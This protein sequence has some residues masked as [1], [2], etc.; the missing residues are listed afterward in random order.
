MANFIDFIAQL[1]AYCFM[2]FSIIVVIIYLLLQLRFVVYFMGFIQ[3]IVARVLIAATISLFY[4]ICLASYFIHGD[5]LQFQLVDTLIF[6]SFIM[7]SSVGILGI[8]LVQNGGKKLADTKFYG[9]AHERAA[10]ANY[11]IRI[12][13][14]QLGLKREHFN[15]VDEINALF[16]GV[17]EPYPDEN[18]TLVK[19]KQW[20]E[21]E[22]P[23]NKTKVLETLSFIIYL[24]LHPVKK[25]NPAN[26]IGK[27]LQCLPDVNRNI[28]ITLTNLYL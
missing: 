17:N 23:F 7:I 15:Y 10:A 24:Q 2:S 14:H 16:L 21:F 6:I 11:L 12:N 4:L 19:L 5:G 20:F 25:F 26:N 22:N 3:Q 13:C 9:F 8:R 28:C 1:R 18:A 27:W